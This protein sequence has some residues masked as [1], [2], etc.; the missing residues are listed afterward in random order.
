MASRRVIALDVGEKRIG[1]AEADTS[2]RIA[3]PHETIQVD[4]D[5]VR[6]VAEAVLQSGA[7]TLVVGYPRNQSGEPTAQTAYVEQF[8]A[9]L[10]DIPAKLVYQDESMTSVLA[11][12]RLQ[13]QKRPY[14]KEDIDAMAACLILEDYLEHTA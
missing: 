12:Q 1:I 7:D 6:A 13:R 10:Q 9:Q 11:E 2:V 3:V 4:G 8:A 5:E 14:A